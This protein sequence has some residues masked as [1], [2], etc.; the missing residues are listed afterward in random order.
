MWWWAPEIHCTASH[1]YSRSVAFAPSYHDRDIVALLPRTE[2][3]HVIQNGLKQRLGSLVAMPEQALHQLLLSEFLAL[4]VK[5]FGYTVRVQ[6]K[7]V[8]WK[9]AA[10]ADGTAPILE[11]T[12]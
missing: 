12:Q 4:I 9:Q 8:S 3:F 10:L 7:D 11:E 1:Y 5:G 2:F 6:C